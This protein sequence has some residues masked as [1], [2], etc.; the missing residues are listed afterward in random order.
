M[1]ASLLAFLLTQ[2]LILLVGLFVLASLV[3]FIW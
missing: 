1:F 2:Q 3:Y